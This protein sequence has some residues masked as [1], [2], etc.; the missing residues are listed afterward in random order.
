MSES[1]EHLVET[2]K[3]W[4]YRAR[5]IRC[6]QGSNGKYV[7]TYIFNENG[8]VRKTIESVHYE[9]IPSDDPY[10]YEDYEPYCHDHP[11]NDWSVAFMESL[12]AERSFET[13]KN[14]ISEYGK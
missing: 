7:M 2:L 11:Y 14:H 1:Y 9:Y 12:R 5:F 10:G 13:M 3:T 6:N 8:E 4:R